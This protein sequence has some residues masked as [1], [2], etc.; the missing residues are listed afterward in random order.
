MSKLVRHLIYFLVLLSVLSL[1]TAT[2][3]QKKTPAG[4]SFFIVSSVDPPKSE[5]LLKQPTEVTQ[6][7]KVASSTK[8]LDDTGKPIQLSGLRAGDTVWVK[9]ANGNAS[10]PIA[11]SIRKG[12]MTVAELHSLYLDYPEVQ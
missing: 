6:L 1:A 5:I 4:E 10:E 11:I 7:M 8:Y 3:A 9:V 12:P 2:Q